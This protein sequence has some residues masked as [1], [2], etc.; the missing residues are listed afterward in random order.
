MWGKI[1][2]KYVYRE[3]GELMTFV[4]GKKDLKKAK[5]LRER[6]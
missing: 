2:T 6:G 5:K 1:R 3:S 4:W